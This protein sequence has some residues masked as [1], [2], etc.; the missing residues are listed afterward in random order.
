MIKP[1]NVEEQ[2]SNDNHSLV[3][4]GVKE[5]GSEENL[6]IGENGDISE[7]KKEN[8][9]ISEKNKTDQV[10]RLSEMSSILLYSD[11]IHI[12]QLFCSACTSYF[13]RKG[14]D[15]RKGRG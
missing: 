1:P 5:N 8:G 4:N 2:S 14:P 6:H 9:E 10:I 12:H 13:C 3:E 11:I 15:I 7:H